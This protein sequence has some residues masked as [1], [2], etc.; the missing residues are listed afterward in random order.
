MAACSPGRPA[1]L[2]GVTAAREA[3]SPGPATPIAAQAARGNRLQSPEKR[4]GEKII[5]IYT[6]IYHQ[7]NPPR[8]QRKNKKPPWKGN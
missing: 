7:N 6:Y 2:G 4:P 8:T 1:G 5:D 3:L